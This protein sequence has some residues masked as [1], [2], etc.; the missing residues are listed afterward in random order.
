MRASASSCDGRS[1]LKPTEREKKKQS[2]SHRTAHPA[3]VPLLT[4]LNV[5]ELNKDWFWN[6][7]ATILNANL[8]HQKLYSG[9]PGWVL[10]GTSA[11]FQVRFMRVTLTR[12]WSICFS[13][14]VIMYVEGRNVQIHTLPCVPKFQIHRFR[15]MKRWI[16]KEYKTMRCKAWQRLH[17]PHRRES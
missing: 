2:T 3:S 8:E 11:L 9:V 13:I 15:V 10:S 16:N 5:A 17:C 4:C 6:Q 14:D 12:Y 7:K 1:Q